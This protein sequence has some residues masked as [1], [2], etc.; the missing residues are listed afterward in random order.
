MTGSRPGAP[1]PW[2]SWGE[3]R[4]ES[5][6][7]EAFRPARGW[8][9]PRT[10]MHALTARSARRFHGPLLSVVDVDPSQRAAVLEDPDRS[11][12][13]REDG[14]DSARSDE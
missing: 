7:T 13:R 5:R 2:R 10:F 4:L 3:T 6:P 14:V 11:R 8:G 1:A 12:L 9:R